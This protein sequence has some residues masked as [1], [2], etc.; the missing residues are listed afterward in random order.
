MTE[1]VNNAAAVSPAVRDVGVW[2]VTDVYP[3]GCGGSGWSTH[4]LART[5]AARGHRVEVISLDP[6]AEGLSQRVFE[7]IHVTELGVGRA[8]R[9]PLRRLGAQDYA[10]E[11]LERYLAARLEETPRP[12]ILHAQHLHSGPPTVVAAASAASAASVASV[13]STTSVASAVSV[14]SAASVAPVASPGIA[15]V[16]TLRDYWPV[17]LHGTSWWNGKECGGC[18]T[19]N[20]SGCMSEYW[21]WPGALARLMVPWAR[22]RLAARRAGVEAADGVITV[23]DW[24]RRRIEPEAPAARYEALPNIVDAD[25]TRASAQTAA[26]VDIPFEGKYLVAAGKLVA[27][28]G[29][30]RLLAALAESGCELPLVLAGSGPE[31]QRLQQQAAAAAL[32]VHLPGWVAHSSL[33]RLIDSAHA[34]V[35]PS[36]WSEPLSRLLL[37]ALALGTPVITWRSGGNPEHLDS[38]VNAFVVGGAE[39]LGEAIEALGEPGRAQRMGSAGEALAR[40]EFSPESVYPRLMETYAKALRHSDVKANAR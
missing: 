13:A 15:S 22:R 18:S 40:R 6:D 21:G 12:G 14:A 38:G 25:A 3:P 4:A 16:Q 1:V 17:C 32:D 19:A 39:D 9:N 2:L 29:F 11:A 27:T 31:R 5:L 20:L 28:K 36:A 30:D 23:S 24:V 37:E 7:D 35:L 26:P 8:R 34:F 10:H 33:L